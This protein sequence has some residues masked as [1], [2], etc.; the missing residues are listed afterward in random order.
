MNV[1][2]ISDFLRNLEIN[3][4]EPMVK[5]NPLEI[6]VEKVHEK[7]I[8]H[9][10]II[11]DLLNPKG[12]HQTGDIFLR[13]FCDHMGSC[14]II[15][16]ASD[17]RVI[18]ERPI[19]SRLTDKGIRRVDICI[20]IKCQKDASAILIENKLNN[21]KEQ[22]QQ[23]SDYKEGLRAE[24]FIEVK[25]VCLQGVIHK[26]IGADLDISPTNL[27][28]IL[29]SVE[30]PPTNLKSYITLLRNMDTK[31]VYK[32]NARK[33]LQLEAEEIK[34][35]RT[36]YF[37][38]PEISNLLYKD[39]IKNLK[40]KDICF[41]EICSE[42]N[43]GDVYKIISGEKCLQLWNKECYKKG[44][45]KGFFIEIW[46]YDFDRFEIWIKQD[47]ENEKLSLSKH[48]YAKSKQWDKYFVDKNNSYDGSNPMTFYYPNKEQFDNMVEYVYELY[49]D[50]YQ[51]KKE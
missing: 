40:N 27:A 18:R 41:E 28:D 8:C 46:F 13:A 3:V 26:N 35:I 49:G 45:N 9:T 42:D 17:I 2:E 14:N 48:D 44:S 30:T 12:R 32:E 31:E 7:E 11:A 6:F 38:L 5:Y 1:K 21:A 36:L 15:S 22:E 16:N 47:G 50:L 51:D 4:E 33:I 19:K 29:D 24:G 37:S 20:E 43:T 10:T 39:I 23:I 25:T 34:K